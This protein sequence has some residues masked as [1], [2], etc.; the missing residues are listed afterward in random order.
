MKDYYKILDLSPE[1]SQ[2]EIKE[3]YRFLLQAWH[4][5]KWPT[6]SHKARAGEKTKEINK[7]YAVLGDRKK[8][9]DYDRRR[10]SP[11]PSSAEQAEQAEREA[12]R[13]SAEEKRRR[14]YAEAAR[15]RAEKDR[16]RRAADKRRRR[17]EEKQRQ[18]AA[19]FTRQEVVAKVARRESL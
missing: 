13:R 4:P 18:Q 17:A 9:A 7:A 6:P 8:R 3:Q 1:A 15:E 2:Q 10:P 16:R 12:R 11:P 5:D 19:D 14:E